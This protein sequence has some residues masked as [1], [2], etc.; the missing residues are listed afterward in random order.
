MIISY[1]NLT[2]SIRAPMPSKTL[3]KMGSFFY[4]C[5]LFIH[6]HYMF[7]FFMGHHFYFEP[8]SFNWLPFFSFLEGWFFTSPQL[9]LLELSFKSSFKL[10][11]FFTSFVFY[12]GF[13]MLEGLSISPFW[14]PDFSS[15]K[16][17]VLLNPKPRTLSAITT[18]AI[19]S[20]SIFSL[21]LCLQGL[22][23]S[24]SLSIYCALG[25]NPTFNTSCDTSSCVCPH[26]P[27]APPNPLHHLFL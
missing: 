16:D 11:K 13:S 5:H 6:L 20:T 8:F 18:L 9:G 3:G 2:T 1:S 26:V 21:V 15:P 14:A 17:F 27:W 23:F 25:S 12:K 22:G 4:P 10:D 7:H 19:L 24:T